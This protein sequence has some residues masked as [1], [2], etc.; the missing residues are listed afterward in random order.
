M[1]E[2]RV[3]ATCNLGPLIRAQIAAADSLQE[4][5]LIKYRGS[6]EIADLITPEL[7][8]VVT[9]QYTKGGV[10]KDVPKKMRVMSSFANPL[11]GIT[12]VELGC[13][14]TYQSDLVEPETR[15]R[16]GFDVT[17][18]AKLGT[19]SVS[20]YQASDPWNAQ[21]GGE[22]NA[23]GRSFPAAWLLAKC[24]DECGV[25]LGSNPLT[26]TY[27]RQTWD[28][29]RGYVQ[30]AS[31][32]LVSESYVGELDYDEVLQIRSLVAEDESGPVVTQDDLIDVGSVNAGELPAHDIGVEYEVLTL[33]DPDPTD[34]V[35]D[36]NTGGG[37]GQ[38][39]TR[40][41]TV[42]P[43]AQ[44]VIRHRYG[45]YTTTNTPTSETVTE[46]E[47]ID[48]SSRV[49]RTTATHTQALSAAA[50]NF[51]EARL[52]LS[53][54]FGESPVEDR[55]VTA[56]SYDV[57]GR[58][59]QVV[60]SKYESALAIAGRLNIPL[61]FADSVVNFSTSATWLSEQTVV[62]YVYAGT[63]KRT[64]TDRYLLAPL[65]IEGQ[66]GSAASGLNITSADDCL[67]YVSSVVSAGVQLQGTTVEVE[68]AREDEAESAKSPGLVDRKT[69]FSTAE[70]YTETARLTWVT[71]VG[72]NDRR[73][74]FR[75]PYSPHDG[76]LGTVGGFYRTPALAQTMALRY[77]EVQNRILFGYRYGMELQIPPEKMPPVAFHPIY[78]SISDLMVQ[79]RTNN[80]SWV[81]EAGEVVCGLNAIL[82]GTAGT[83]LGSPP[84]YDVANSWVP[85]EPGTT[86][87]GAAPS[88]S[89]DPDY[90]TVTISSGLNKP[91][92]QSVDY[93][94]R[95]SGS[96]FALTG[97]AA[98]GHLRVDYTLDAGSRSFALTGKAAGTAKGYGSE[99]EAG[100]FTLTGQDAML[101]SNILY[102]LAVEPGSFSLGGIAADI[103]WDGHYHLSAEAGTLALTG[104]AVSTFDPLLVNPSLWVDADDSG[105][106]TLVSS[107][108]S[109]WADK[110]GNGNNLTMDTTTARPTVSS[111]ALNGKD[112]ILFDGVNDYLDRPGGT[113]ADILSG[114][115]FS[116]LVVV[117]AATINT[118]SGFTYNNDAVWSDSAGY[119]SAFFR[120]S[121]L[122][123][124]HVFNGTYRTATTSYTANN[125]VIMGVELSS[126]TLRLRLNGGT[127]A[128]AA[129]ASI[130]I[131]DGRFQVGRNNMAGTFLDGSIAEMIA[132]QTAFN[133]AQRQQVEGYLAHKWG[134]ESN[135]PSEHPYK[136]T[137]P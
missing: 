35:D 70:N 136:T 105:T 69:S 100:S 48:G 129:S 44:I 38:S 103:T 7:G 124:V 113:L 6:C 62:T 37:E 18:V 96:T 84:S 36:G 13:L 43:S 117:N 132:S 16:K 90:G 77:G 102:G 88:T 34:G 41:Y 64:V 97:N 1:L 111:A 79:Y 107:A 59:Y 94:M 108:V 130:S 122:A 28:F 123:G 32:L 11:T 121:G 26:N 45:T 126:S 22:Y 75:L 14:L 83:T 25:E 55:T 3:T 114:T 119:A 21:T 98:E 112:V 128:T 49:V 2:G 99:A 42:G 52:S 24:M 104:T 115:Q 19:Q 47:E 30:I 109:A 58:L 29:S 46:Y 67:D 20:S 27:R 82:W 80:P 65:T 135:L 72:I 110:S 12:T 101:A 127:E 56:N 5:G 89:A 39:F 71:G 85:L 120:S 4:T 78:I 53:Q 73:K 93:R 91:Y 15:L 106:I 9:F 131:L 95:A 133:A 61:T 137:P 40:T 54:P 86:S 116:C 17:F 33:S 92:Q 23:I 63:Q 74:V 87:L 134:L 31:D 51:A 68:L 8:A 50:G 76:L 10:T 118:D 66:Q 57:D 81:I 125:W 60:T